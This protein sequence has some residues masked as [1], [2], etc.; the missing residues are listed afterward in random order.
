MKRSRLIQAVGTVI[1]GASMI[2]LPACTT[3]PVGTVAPRPGVGVVAERDNDFDWGW[4][5]LVGLVGLFGLSG[6]KGNR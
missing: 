2:I 6:K 4:I 3:E 5:G 1:L